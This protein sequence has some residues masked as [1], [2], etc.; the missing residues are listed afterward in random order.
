MVFLYLPGLKLTGN[1]ITK[2][3]N[4]FFIVPVQPLG[5]VD[6]KTSHEHFWISDRF[7]VRYSV[8]RWLSTPLNEI[9]F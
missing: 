2:E 1:Y 8:G 6:V 9:A 3:V 7:L 5:F 4:L